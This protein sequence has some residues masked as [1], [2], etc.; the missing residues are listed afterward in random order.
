[1]LQSN[2]DASSFKLQPA[3]RPKSKK[4]P[5]HPPP[6]TAPAANTSSST[7]SAHKGSASGSDST[8]LRSCFEDDEDEAVTPRASLINVPLLEHDTL[9]SAPPRARSSTFS[10]ATSSSSVSRLLASLSFPASPRRSMSAAVSSPSHSPSATVTLVLSD[11]SPTP[12]TPLFP[13]R[14]LMRSLSSACVRSPTS[15]GSTLRKRMGVRGTHAAQRDETAIAMSPSSPLTPRR[16]SELHTPTH[17]SIASVLEGEPLSATLKAL[18]AKRQTQRFAV[19]VQSPLADVDEFELVT[20]TRKIFHLPTWVRFEANHHAR[21]KVAQEN[22]QAALEYALLR[23]GVLEKELPKTSQL[24]DAAPSSP[25]GELLAGFD[26]DSPPL[27][28]QQEEDGEYKVSVVRRPTL[29]ALREMDATTDSQGKGGVLGA[30]RAAWPPFRPQRRIKASHTREYPRKALLLA[31]SP[32]ATEHKDR[33]DGWGG[34]LTRS[35]WFPSHTKGPLVSPPASSAKAKRLKT[36]LLQPSADKHGKHSMDDEWE[37]V[38]EPSGAQAPA[39]EHSFLELH[40][41][42]R[43]FNRP[44]ATRPWIASLFPARSTAERALDTWH[45]IPLQPLPAAAAESE[46]ASQLISKRTSVENRPLPPQPSTRTRVALAAI[47]LI[48]VLAIVA[49]VVIITRAHSDSHGS[50]NTT[51]KAYDP[52][53]GN[54]SSLANTTRQSAIAQAAQ[55][56]QP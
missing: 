15:P 21:T 7:L 43:F 26:L 18:G 31:P 32:T 8:S 51:L 49:N 13:R 6:L 34:V 20:A 47:A 39:E 9:A 17:A 12:S 33:R 38:L 3:P 22:R 29:A 48:M 4:R 41:A 42:P 2:T 16:A 40:D 52:L 37:D 36:I 24:G 10:V 30:L 35:S 53:V 55:L 14:T 19:P 50:T 25:N 11:K 44:P 27:D 23:K 28:T 54:L 1:M 56:S 5:Q 46:V 45:S